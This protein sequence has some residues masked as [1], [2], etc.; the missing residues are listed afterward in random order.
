MYGGAGLDL[1]EAGRGYADLEGGDDGDT[2]VAGE[3]SGDFY[4]DSSLGTSRRDTI[5][6]SHLADPI[7]VYAVEFNEF[8][9]HGTSSYDVWAPIGLLIGT[10]FNDTIASSL[11]D[12]SHA[13][14]ATRR[15]RSAKTILIIGSGKAERIDGGP[16]DDTIHGMGGNDNLGGPG[17]QLLWRRGE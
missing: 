4:I 16:G 7:H 17:R 15:W 1:L 13:F 3:G 12:D 10:P 6:C 11:S 14:F 9:D 5:D 8:I 2:L